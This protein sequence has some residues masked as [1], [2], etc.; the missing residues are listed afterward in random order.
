[1]HQ[2]PRSTKLIYED[3]DYCLFSVTLFKRVA[4]SFKAAARTKGFQVCSWFFPC[5]DIS[6]MHHI[7]QSDQQH[8][9]PLSRPCCFISGAMCCGVGAGA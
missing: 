6:C 7:A 5:L 9:N 3:K 1:M 2:V 8:V 4:D